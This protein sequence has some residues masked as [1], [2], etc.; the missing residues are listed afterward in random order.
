VICYVKQVV[1]KALICG[2]HGRGTVPLAD[3]GKENFL[4]RRDNVAIF[5]TMAA[6]P[7]LQ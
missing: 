6:S 2:A 4:H 3:A 1:T 5:I 7:I